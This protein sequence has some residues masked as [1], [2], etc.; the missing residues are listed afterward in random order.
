MMPKAAE[1]IERLARENERLKFENEML[2]QRIAKLEA[3]E[4]EA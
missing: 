3:E 2:K 4:T 1:T